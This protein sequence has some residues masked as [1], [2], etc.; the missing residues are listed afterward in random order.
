[1]KKITFVLIVFLF[2]AI[3]GCDKNYEK[4]DP[5]DLLIQS[6]LSSEEFEKNEILFN[7]YGQIARDK[8]SIESLPVGEELVKYLMIPILKN[9][10]IVAY[11]QVLEVKTKNLPNRD[12]YAMNLIDLINFNNDAITGNIRM[13]DLNYDGFMHSNIAVVNKEVLSWK[14]FSM[15][16]EIALKYEDLRVDLSKGYVPCDSN[17]NGNLGFFEC[18]SCFNDAIDSNE[19]S[20]FICDIPIGGWIACFASVSIACAY[21]SM[22]Y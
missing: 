9:D 6:F 8:I 20:E 4:A 21:L 16:Q 3:N 18:Y 15:P 7:S 11:V 13:F 2:I 12:T 1:M 22:A 19:M 14:S 10:K 17:G 5:Q